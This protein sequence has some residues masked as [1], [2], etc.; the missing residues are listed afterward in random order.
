MT[1]TLTPGADVRESSST[2]P[3]LPAGPPAVIGGAVVVAVLYARCRRVAAALIG[4]SSPRLPCGPSPSRAPQ[5][6]RPAGRPPSS[7]LPSCWRCSRWSASCG[8][9]SR[10]GAAVLSAEFFTYSMRNVV[11]EG[12][13]IYHAHHR[14]PA[15]HRRCAAVI[16]VP[17]GLLTAIYLVEYG[18]GGRLA[19][20]ITFL[21][22]VMTGIPSIVAGL[23]AYA[24]FVL[25]FGAGRPD[26]LRRRRSR[27]RC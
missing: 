20:W 19:R 14:H 17:I 12:G 13:G 24:L 18:E 22:D 5:G 16:S 15:H 25:F 4:W 7:R 21:V 8:R 3:Q 9:S 23:F 10:K 1:T 26:G 2:A 6:H 27:C 11:G